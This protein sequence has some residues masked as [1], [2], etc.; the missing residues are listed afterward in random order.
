MD[1]GFAVAVNAPE[2]Q[3]ATRRKVSLG[4]L[5]TEEFSVSVE[6]AYEELT[7]KND[8]LLPQSCQLPCPTYDMRAAPG[9]TSRVASTVPLSWPISRVFTSAATCWVVQPRF[10]IAISRS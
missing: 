4:E 10:A 8:W 3:S 2:M 5:V 7:W 9:P 6:S 1:V